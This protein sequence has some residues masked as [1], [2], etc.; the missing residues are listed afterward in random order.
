MNVVSTYTRDD[1][2]SVPTHT[3]KLL[4]G[5]F[6]HGRRQC[7]VPKAIFSKCILGKSTTTTK[8]EEIV[9]LFCIVCCHVL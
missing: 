4:S 7:L 3:W 5:L 8:M 6:I 9:Y 1:L 2:F